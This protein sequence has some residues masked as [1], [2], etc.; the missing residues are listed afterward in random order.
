VTRLHDRG[1]GYAGQKVIEEAGETVVAALQGQDDA[2]LEEA[3]D[4]L[5]HLSAL[6]ALRGRRLDEVA[7]VLDARHRE[8][9]GEHAHD[10]ADPEGA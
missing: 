3:A 2:F 10:A 4:L 8:R 7:Q 9:G 6:V 1:I 5:F